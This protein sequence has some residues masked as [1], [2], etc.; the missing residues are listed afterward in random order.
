[1]LATC[2]RFELDLDRDTVE[3][4]ERFDGGYAVIDTRVPRV[5]SS[6]YLVIEPGS[7]LAAEAIVEL[8]DEHLGGAGLAHRKLELMDIADAE[9]LGPELTRLGWEGDRTLY[10]VLRRAPDREAD[11]T[12]S[13]VDPASLAELRKEIARDEDGED[14]EVGLQL[15][16]REIRLGGIADGR[17]FAVEREGEVAACCVLYRRGGTGQVEAVTTS[18]RHRNQGMAR[19]LVLAAAEASREAGDELTFIAADAED[20]PKQLYERLGF[21][22]VGETAGF[23]LKPPQSP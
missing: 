13:A 23:V 5:W 1:M 4:V 11:V 16:E 2:H 21:D 15:L 6:N 17:W 14:E 10:M 22:P 12:P 8:G 7:G 9:R 19:A 3:R 18:P 20:W